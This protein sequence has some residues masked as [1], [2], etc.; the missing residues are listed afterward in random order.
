MLL[1]GIAAAVPGLAGFVSFL[2]GPKPTDRLDTAESLVLLLCGVAIPL[3]AAS[4]GNNFV[5]AGAAAI[6]VIVLRRNEARRREPE[7]RERR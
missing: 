3:L 5:V 4:S 1:I 6:N 2:V 7:A